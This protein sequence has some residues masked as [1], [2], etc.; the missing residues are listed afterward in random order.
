MVL[1]AQR[2]DVA[3][4]LDRIEA[5]VKENYNIL[6]KQD[7]VARRMAF[8]TQEFNSRSNAHA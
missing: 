2:I 1:L 5:H 6:K 8:R 7:A 3:E 4:E